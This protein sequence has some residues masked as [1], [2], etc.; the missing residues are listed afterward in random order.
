MYE[1]GRGVQ[2]S[3]VQA[4]EWYRRAADQGYAAAQLN[5]STLYFNGSGVPKDG[6]L[7]Y[8]WCLVSRAQGNMNAQKNVDTIGKTLS[9]EQRTEVQALA[10]AWKRKDF[11][12]N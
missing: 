3:F 11:S 8:L 6:K 10:R 9:A 7:A 4:V 2:R 5:L 12:P 1:N